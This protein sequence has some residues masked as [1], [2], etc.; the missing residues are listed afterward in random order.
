[1]KKYIV[2]LLAVV[3]CVMVCVSP[4]AYAHEYVAQKQAM[5]ELVDV[6]II[7]TEGNRLGTV[8]MTQQSRI[9]IAAGATIFYCG[10]KTFIYTTKGW[11]YLHPNIGEDILHFL[12]DAFTILQNSVGPVLYAYH[13]GDVYNQYE[14]TNGQICVLERHSDRWMCKY[15]V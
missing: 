6:D 4:V 2:V 15:S 7:D 11:L 10:V 12:L 9:S 3:M 13:N 1:M 14:D 5:Q 8:Q